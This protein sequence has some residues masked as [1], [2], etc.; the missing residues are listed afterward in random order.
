M[1]PLF[2]RISLQPPDAP[3]PQRKKNTLRRKGAMGGGIPGKEAGCTHGS[4]DLGM[5]VPNSLMRSLMLKRRRRST[6]GYWEGS[7]GQ[8]HLQTNTDTPRATGGPPDP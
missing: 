8:Q 1:V 4:L 7:G 5:R 2:Q 3:P 6:A